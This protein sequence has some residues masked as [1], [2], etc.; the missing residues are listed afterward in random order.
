MFTYQGWLNHIELAGHF[1][2]ISNLCC[3]IQETK[4]KEHEKNDGNS[5]EDWPCNSEIEGSANGASSDQ[6]NWAA[7]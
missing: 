2:W 4:E 5:Q 3:W 6:T 7:Q 1:Q